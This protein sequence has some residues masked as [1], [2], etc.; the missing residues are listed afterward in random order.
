MKDLHLFGR[1]HHLVEAGVRDL[2]EVMVLI[3]VAYI[4]GDGV[5]GAIVAIRLLTLQE[6]AS[7]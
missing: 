7:K 6:Q 1:E 2:R 5:Q 3:V 4:V